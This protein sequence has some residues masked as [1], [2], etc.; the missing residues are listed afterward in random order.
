M[1]TETLKINAGLDAAKETEEEIIF[2]LAKLRPLDY[3]RIR[4][5]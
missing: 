3:D 1:Q 2:R 4:R 5:E